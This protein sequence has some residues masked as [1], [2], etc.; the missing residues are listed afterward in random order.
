[1]AKIHHFKILHAGWEM[2]TKGHVEETPKG[3]RTLHTTN[4]GDECIMPKKELLAKI[5]ETQDSLEGLLKAKELM[6]Y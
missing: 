1:M 4:H 6:K 2:D 5:Q 3:K